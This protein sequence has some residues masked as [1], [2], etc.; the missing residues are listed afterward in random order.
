M[1][2]IYFAS[3]DASMD[4]EKRRRLRICILSPLMRENYDFFHQNLTASSLQV[5][6]C[7]LCFCRDIS[8]DVDRVAAM[9]SV[10]AEIR[11]RGGFVMSTPEHIL[12]MKLKHL[13]LHYS[14]ETEEERALRDM[15]TDIQEKEVCV[16]DESDAALCHKYQLVY[17][18]GTPEA[19]ASG[20]IRWSAFQALLYIVNNSVSN[21]SRLMN[22]KTAAVFERD[23]PSYAWSRWRLTHNCG[24]IRTKLR[25]ALLNEIIAS[26]PNRELRWLSTWTSRGSSF[27]G[28][29]KR[30]ILDPDTDAMKLMEEIV[31]ADHKAIVLVLRG[32]LAMGIFEHVLEQRY[33]V[34]YGRSVVKDGDVPC[35]RLAVPYRS[36]D[37]PA[38]RAEFSQPDVAIG[39]TITMFWT[40][41]LSEEE[42][43]EAIK[44]LLLS[45]TALRKYIYDLWLDQV[46]T[47]LD[48][49]SFAKIDSVEKID[50]NNATRWA[51]L[52]KIF[53]LCTR[54]IDF[55]LDQCVFHKD[56][57]QYSQQI[58]ATPWNL[59]DGVDPVGFSGTNDLQ[60]LLP[61]QV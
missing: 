10:S 21:V 52:Y 19:L 25:S 51:T 36:T 35:K 22:T 5:A 26:P 32:L 61:G 33:R 2:F 45:T 16:F 56:T 7:R 27:V 53:H 31:E 37:V 28:K 23:L 42:L 58:M 59:T 47:S 41:G 55:F 17:A 40:S 34:D 39:L 49:V 48:P 50:L 44:K 38:E 54:A 3:L 6:I 20:R 29:M 13:E 9:R 8:I 30:I 12:S 24:E 57:E 14:G 46:C 15:L 60:L 4:L 1:L 43:H 11:R 18:V